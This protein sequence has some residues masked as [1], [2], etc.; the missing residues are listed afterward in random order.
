MGSLRYWMIFQ[1]VLG[2]WLIVSPFVLGFREITKM[3]INDMILGGIVVILGVG[4]ALTGLPKIRP[5]E[6][7]M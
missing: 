2:I 7:G 4:V 1:V 5:L 6:K 3:T